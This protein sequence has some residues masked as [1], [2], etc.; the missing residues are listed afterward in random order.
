MDTKKTNMF[1]FKT[2]GSS[3]RYRCATDVS[4][5]GPKTKK[6]GVPGI[7]EIRVDSTDGFI[8]LWAEGQYLRWGFDIES[9]DVFEDPVYAMQKVKE[10]IDAALEAW[11]WQPI[12]FVY[13]ENDTDFRVVMKS[14]KDC[15]QYG[16]VLASAFFP[17]SN[18]DRVFLYPTLFEQDTTEIVN[19]LEH[20]IGHIFGLRHYFAG[21]L[22]SDSP[23]ELF[24]EDAE[25]S[26]MNYGTLSV[27]TDADRSDLQRLYEEAWSKQ[28]THLNNAEIRFI[29]PYRT[30]GSSALRVANSVRAKS[31]GPSF[32]FKPSTTPSLAQRGPKSFSSPAANPLSTF[33]SS[34]RGNVES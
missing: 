15:D 18:Q 26:I 4:I 31:S 28:L 22:E 25:Q 33:R 23:S 8:P 14:Q 30:I 34:R 13:Q 32:S 5:P 16:C 7:A 2:K 3:R 10:F 11:G 1:R 19:T 12:T 6:P 24:G 17:S 27:M 29:Y 20:E 21:T 9:F